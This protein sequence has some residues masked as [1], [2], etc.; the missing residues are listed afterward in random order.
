MERALAQ[1]TASLE[2]DEGGPADDASRSGTPPGEVPELRSVSPW[3]ECPDGTR[4]R[5]APPPHG[6]ER[7]CERSGP[8]ASTV[9]HGGYAKWH[10]NARIHETGIFVDGAREG[11]WTRWNARA[12]IQTQA[13]FRGGLQHGFQIDWEESGV[14]SREVRFARGEPVGR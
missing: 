7:W 13:E 14:R 3:F 8:A 9:R 1:L 4:E 2:G 10:G 5:G 11:V 6:F 12:R